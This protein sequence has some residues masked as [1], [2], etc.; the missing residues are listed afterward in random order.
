MKWKIEKSTII[1][2]CKNTSVLVIK[3]ADRKSV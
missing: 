1:V 2:G 3:Q